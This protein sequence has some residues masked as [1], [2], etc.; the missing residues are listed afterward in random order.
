M[1]KKAILILISILLIISVGCSNGDGE[2]NTGEEN[3]TPPAVENGEEE[4]EEPEEEQQT[5]E[6]LAQIAYDEYLEELESL[7]KDRTENLGEF[8]I[9]LPELSFEEFKDKDKPKEK[10]EAKGIFL[11]GSSAGM[12]LDDVDIEN[13]AA[14]VKALR[15]G[16][17]QKINELLPV[18]DGINRFERAVALAIETEV[19]AFVRRKR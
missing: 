8:Y 18:I 15:E 3:T 17:Q 13:Y 11:T 16:D 1:I 4:P 12:G 10:V 6:E 7:E 9:K 5:E 14:Y 2:P 19:N